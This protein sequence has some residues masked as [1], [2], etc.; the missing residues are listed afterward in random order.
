MTTINTQKDAIMVYHKSEHL[1]LNIIQVAHFVTTIDSLNDNEK[2]G[3]KRII[4]NIIESLI[5]DTKSAAISTHCNEFDQSGSILEQVI[6]LTESNKFD[7]ASEKL[8]EAIT[9]ITTI[10][11]SAWDVLHNH[12]LI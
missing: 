6:T 4:I 7:L 2:I 10:A 5:S 12:E 3:A 9:P 1:K 8:G 11:V